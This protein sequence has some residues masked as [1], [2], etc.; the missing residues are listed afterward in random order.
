MSLFTTSTFASLPSPSRP[1]LEL[2]PLELRA[3]GLLIALGVIAA[4]W[5]CGRMLERYGS[6]TSDDAS[7]VAMWGV[8]AGIIG[9]RLYHVAT[10]WSRFSDDLG[11]IPQVWKGGLGIP[12]G[13]LAGVLA[14]VWQGRRRGIAPMVLLTCAAPAVPLAQAIGRWGNWFNQELYGRPTDLPWGL[15]IDLVPIGYLPGTTFHPTFLYE[16]LWNF[17]LVGALLVVDRRFRLGPGRL[18]A[19]YLV[20][21]GLGR[22]WIEGLRIDPTEVSDVAGLRWNQWVALA[23]VVAG[24]IWF[25]RTRSS[26]WPAPDVLESDG[27]AP[28]VLEPDGPEPE[29]VESADDPVGDP[30]RAD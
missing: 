25:A 8:I 1:S 18:F 15:E 26:R 21:Y 2:G 27:P 14:G 11:A 9:A 22:F 28:D 19:L 3:Y 7:S 29:M 17:G 20:G 24:S 12:G 16:S 13:L 10:E 30:N 4:V 5:L 6:G 23:A